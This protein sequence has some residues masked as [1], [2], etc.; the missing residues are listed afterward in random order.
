[1]PKTR[2]FSFS[3]K[4]NGRARSVGSAVAPR[5]APQRGHVRQWPAVLAA[6]AVTL[7][8]HLLWQPACAA[9]A[10]VEPRVALVIGNAEYDT[11]PKYLQADADVASVVELLHK[12]GFEVI[13]RHN[14]SLKEMTRLLDEVKSRLAQQRGGVAIFYFS[15]H[16]EAFPLPEHDHDV[17]FLVPRNGVSGKPGTLLPLSTATAAIRV[18]RPSDDL[19]VNIVVVDACRDSPKSANAVGSSDIEVPPDTLVAYATSERSFAFSGGRLSRYTDCLV[20]T[21][22]SPEYASGSVRALFGRAQD[23]VNEKWGPSQIPNFNDKLR[24]EFFFT[25]KDDTD[26]R[27]AVLDREMER[28]GDAASPL[29]YHD[30]AIAHLDNVARGRAST[31][32]ALAFADVVAAEEKA[33]ALA[34]PNVD[35]ARQVRH[36]GSRLFLLCPQYARVDL[37]CPDGLTGVTIESADH[38]ARHVVC[39]AEPAVVFPAVTHLRAE[40]DGIFISEETKSHTVGSGKSR[41]LVNDPLLP[42]ETFKARLRE[43]AWTFFPLLVELDFVVGYRLGNNRA[44]SSL[45]LGFDTRLG[46]KIRIS[47]RSML[48]LYGVFDMREGGNS[49]SCDDHSPPGCMQ[50]PPV[51]SFNTLSTGGGFGYGRILGASPGLFGFMSDVQLR[52][53]RVTLFLNDAQLQD[54][55]LPEVVVRIGANIFLGSVGFELQRTLGSPPATGVDANAWAFGAYLGLKGPG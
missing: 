55:W 24:R 37:D 30:R 1:M 36:V 15:G 6:L 52:A 49:G 10:P 29:A 23:C 31:E 50:A 38:P 53:T 19:P 32:C 33:L 2:Q 51:Y 11:Y 39:G 4:P 5:R 21:L 25:S 34:T 14:Q 7:L 28:D 26:L 48:R 47:A 20:S 40:E 13:E 17:Q 18:R 42:G 43:S 41:F 44:W 45:S 9:Q 46:A 35:L 16:G 8:V 27:I 22:R 12:Y 54:V 3:G